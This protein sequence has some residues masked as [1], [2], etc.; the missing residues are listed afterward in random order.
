MTF[1]VGS[2]IKERRKLLKLTQKELAMKVGLTEFNISKYERDYSSPD[3]DAIK[4]LAFAL[5]CTVDYLVG[6]SDNPNAKIYT[7][8]NIK[9]EM[10]ETY[11]YDLTP[12]Q[13]E[14]LVLLLKN[15][16]FD[17]ESLI[18]DVKNG[19]INDLL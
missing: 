16:R 8:E 17:V 18:D 6:K 11:P 12:E 2:R 13:V 1:S 3:L 14:K 10:K 15:S 19:K 4:N 7:H 9:I 5:D